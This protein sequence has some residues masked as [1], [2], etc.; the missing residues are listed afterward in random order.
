MTEERSTDPDRDTTPGRGQ[1]Q[2]DWLE[3]RLQEAL[4]AWGYATE[5][6]VPIV[7]QT[8]D[9]VARRQDLADEPSDYLVAE[10]KDWASRPID[11]S[12]LIRLC[13]LAFMARAMPVLCH[14]SRLT[15]RAWR[16][17]QAYD[18]R[19]LSLADLEGDDL[20]PLTR[21]RPPKDAETHRQSVVPEAL[22]EI[23]P[24]PLQRL[25][26]DPP[27]V[28]LEGPV[29]PGAETAPCYVA[30]RTGHETYTDTGLERYRR[31]EQYRQDT[32]TEDK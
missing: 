5:R 16:L 4:E 9:V 15:D 22:R 28:E 7:A 3:L 31:R 12:V 1:G 18:V 2:G 19:L 13:L 20:P 21:K 27:G 32:S 29:Y 8:A 24:T 14:T 6:R 23:P 25:Q 30:D 26:D 17:A 11:E 10:C